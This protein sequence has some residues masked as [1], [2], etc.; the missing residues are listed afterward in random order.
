MSGF[1]IRD[2]VSVGG[3]AP[4]LVIAGP[5]ALESA[6]M[7]LDVARRS[8]EIC[9][10]LGL[11]YVF[12]ASFDKANRTSGTSYR[13]PGLE[14]G[15]RILS[16]ITQEVN[17][18]VTT[19]I[20]E[21]QHASVVGEVVDMIQIPAF[22]CRQ[23]ELL[24]A[25]ART[26]KP[27][28][29][30]K[31]Q[32]MAPWDMKHVVAKL[33]AGGTE[34]ILLTERGS[35]FGYNKLVVDMRSLVYMQDLDVPIAFDATHSVQAP[36]AAGNESGGDRDH[37]PHLARGAAAVGID[38]IFLE[39]HPDPSSARSDGSVM[40]PLDRLHDLLRGLRDI[41]ITLDG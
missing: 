27:V 37:A 38:A 11:G 10:D 20:H 8:A 3:Q 39:T 14:E 26:G 28:N 15:L 29:V 30:K 35:M 34:R 40:L 41:R 33:R 17:V 13:G 7:A 22:L 9:R 16:A 24:D 2:G 19:D 21:S 23:T 25:A 36:G 12:K 4:L 5:C 18:P 32:F 6:D 31:G 1:E